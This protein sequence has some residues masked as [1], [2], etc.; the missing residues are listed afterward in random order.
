MYFNYAVISLSI[1][2]I[3][4]FKLSLVSLMVSFQSG[5]WL[6][7]A[8]KLMVVILLCY[9]I[10]KE[11][12]NNLRPKKEAINQTTYDRSFLSV[13]MAVVGGAM[14]TAVLNHYLNLG[15]VIASSLVGLLGVVMMKKYQIPIYCGSFVGMASLGVLANY[16]GIL[17]AAGLSGFLF[18]IAGNVFIGFGGKLGAI[19]Y[20]G[21]FLAAVLT[22][23]IAET[24]RPDTVLLDWRLVFYFTLAA[25]GTYILNK[26]SVHGAVASS[27]LVGLLFALFIP[28]FHDTSAGFLAVGAFCGTFIGMSAT[29]RLKNTGQILLAG[30]IGSLI[31]TY[32]QH[33]FIGLGGKLGAMAFVASIATAGIFDVM[34][35]KRPH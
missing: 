11:W 27:S 33:Y 29:S 10:S 31:F 32:T 30:I 18:L 34:K 7:F 23:G 25:A 1:F 14:L 4:V 8:V 26:R 6:F 15:P 9:E 2:C 17:L 28:F 5:D 16:S 24:I 20:F 3:I 21:T 22:G 19:A 12:L 35:N 13:F